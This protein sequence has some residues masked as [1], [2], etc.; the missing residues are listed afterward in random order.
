MTYIVLRVLNETRPMYWYAL[1][2]LLFVLSQLAWFLLGK[3]ICKVRYFALFFF[4]GSVLVLVVG[5]FCTYV[6]SIVIFFVIS[7]YPRIYYALRIPPNSLQILLLWLLSIRRNARTNATFTA[8]QCSCRRIVHSD[9]PRDCYCGRDL[10]GLEEY[11]GRCV[12]FHSSCV[13]GYLLWF[14][15]CIC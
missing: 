3:V 11:Y 9:H 10:Y 2:A 12:S 8:L 7:A 4:S 6:A 5:R 14:R 13:L 1:A 15:A